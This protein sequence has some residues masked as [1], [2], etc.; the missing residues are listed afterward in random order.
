MSQPNISD[1]EL[2]NILGSGSYST[3]YRARNKVSYRIVKS[4]ALT[5][6]RIN[7]QTLQ[8]T[9]QYVAIKSVSQQRLTAS[10]TENLLREIKLLKTLRH[11][12]I[13]EMF[14]FRWDNRNIYLILELCHQGDLSAYIKN[15]RTLPETTCKFFLRQVA[16]ALQYM[17]ENNVSHFDLKPQNLLLT[18][19]PNITIKVAD[20][21]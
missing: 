6:T 10:S 21:G 7:S 11:R 17:R 5:N 12:Y 1:F 9:N 2:L 19:A 15:H 4:K 20:F 16:L 3:V 18:K 14:D 8:T 13:V